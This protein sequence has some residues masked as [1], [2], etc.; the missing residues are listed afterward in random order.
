MSLDLATAARELADSLE[1]SV[2][3]CTTRT[4]H[5]RVAGHAA[6]ARW[7]ANS[8]QEAQEPASSPPASHDLIYL[9][10]AG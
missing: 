5:V 10:S 9:P 8:L 6:R 7:L 1:A 2:T 4:E 3:L